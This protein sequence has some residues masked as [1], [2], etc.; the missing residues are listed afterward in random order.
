MMAR[1]KHSKNESFSRNFVR[2]FVR[3]P[4]KLMLKEGKYIELAEDCH[5]LT[6]CQISRPNQNLKTS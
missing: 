5:V 6:D 2:V 4:G 3:V 1:K